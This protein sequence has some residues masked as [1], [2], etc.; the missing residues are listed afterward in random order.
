MTLRNIANYLRLYYLAFAVLILDQGSKIWIL[1]TIRPGTGMLYSHPIPIIHDFFYLVHIHNTGAAWGQ[2][3]G[4]T[5]WLALLAIIALA[6]IYF[7][8]K[9]L[10]V[11]KHNV[12][13]AFGLLIGGVVGNF[14]DRVFHGYVIDFLDFHLGSYRWPAF[15]IAD[16]GITI[17][18]ALY[19]LRSCGK[20][21]D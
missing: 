4:Q 1:K 12:Q 5:L 17:G 8:S 3:S 16:C 10:E 15:N 20:K 19:I 14:I 11:Y 2:L 18:V 7:F 9:Q 6:L 13:Y 21:H